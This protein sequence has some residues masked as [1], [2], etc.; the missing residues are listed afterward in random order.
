MRILDRGCGSPLAHI[1]EQRSARNNITMPQSHAYPSRRAFHQPHPSNISTQLHHDHQQYTPLFTFL[2]PLILSPPSAFLFLPLISTSDTHTALVYAK[3]LAHKY[4]GDGYIVLRFSFGSCFGRGVHT[5]K[6]GKGSF[7]A[8]DGTRCM[9]NLRS[10][11]C[12]AP[13]APV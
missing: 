12:Y 5:E 3:G 7:R 1:Y 8:H 9:G 4:P 11:F 10:I 6:T 13:S 2:Y